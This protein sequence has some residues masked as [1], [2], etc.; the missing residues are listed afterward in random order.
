[1]TLIADA[2]VDVDAEG[3]LTDPE[4]WNEQI[5]QAIAAEN[6]VSELCAPGQARAADPQR[7]RERRL[8]T[9]VPATVSSGVYNTA[10][11]ATFPQDFIRRPELTL[12]CGTSKYTR[13]RP[14]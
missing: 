11:A 7:P 12:T 13:P 2:P 10:E 8:Q 4:Q 9:S 1:M 6:G 14:S 5:G 3:F